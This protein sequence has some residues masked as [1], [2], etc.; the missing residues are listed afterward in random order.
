MFEMWGVLLCFGTLTRHNKGVRLLE[1]SPG[2]TTTLNSCLQVN[3]SIIQHCERN[4][5]D[6][7]Y[8]WYSAGGQHLLIILVYFRRSQD[9]C[10]WRRIFKMFSPEVK[11][12]LDVLI[13]PPVTTHSLNYQV[14]LMLMCDLFPQQKIY[15]HI[16][17]STVFMPSMMRQTF[18][19]ISKT[20]LI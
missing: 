19:A 15:Y 5:F 10:S 13:G 1:V 16:F 11:K 3:A 7:R 8:C 17:M 12:H 20:F 6:R 2:P 18:P 9:F 14:T 4:H